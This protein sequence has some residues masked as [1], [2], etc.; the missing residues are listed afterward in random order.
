MPRTPPVDVTTET[1]PKA[2]GITRRSPWTRETGAWLCLLV[3]LGAL[4]IAVYVRFVADA[5][6]GRWRPELRGHPL[7]ELSIED[8]NSSA[9]TLVHPSI[10]M[11][12]T[13][14][15]PF[16]Y[17]AVVELASLRRRGLPDSTRVYVIVRAGR[18]AF[19]L[20]LDRI[21]DRAPVLRLSR[22]STRLAFVTDVPLT[23]RTDAAG[24]IVQAFVG[25]PNQELLGA[26]R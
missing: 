22:P 7:G 23:V 15:C 1:P 13:P 4:A 5:P 10:L 25:M 11:F 16:C 14:E 19:R 9:R 18:E 17:D 21:E 3:S 20:F 8:V 24:A 6:R 26:P 12:V 2:L